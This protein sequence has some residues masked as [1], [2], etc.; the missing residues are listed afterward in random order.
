MK[1]V[2]QARRFVPRPGNHIGVPSFASFHSVLAQ[3]QSGSVNPICNPFQF[4]MA[5]CMLT[6]WTVVEK[7]DRPACA[8]VDSI[9]MR[10]V[11]PGR[12]YVGLRERR[13]D[14]VERAVLTSA[15]PVA[16]Q[17][18][19]FLKTTFSMA[20]VAHYATRSQGA[21]RAFA[22]ILV[23]KV[24]R[25]ASY[26]WKVWHFHGDLPLQ[27]TSEAGVAFITSEWEEIV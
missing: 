27:V 7:V 21:D 16:S 11:N 5:N 23:K 4:G 25:D 13:E 14:A 24:Y 8:S 9:L 17:T 12:D 19:I 3:I 26:D 18:H 15:M 1:L 22:P 6:T 10:Y 2:K 20:G